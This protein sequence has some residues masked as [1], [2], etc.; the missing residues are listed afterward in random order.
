MSGSA[1]RPGKM[2]TPGR[3]TEKKVAVERLAGGL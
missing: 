3:W 1:T 2:V